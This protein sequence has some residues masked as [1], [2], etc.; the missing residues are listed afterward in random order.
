MMCVEGK[1]ETTTAPMAKGDNGSGDSHGTMTFQS[2]RSTYMAVI[3]S[4]YN[5][6]ETSSYL[7]ILIT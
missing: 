4:D 3:S 2:K 5:G 7:G 6:V 1:H